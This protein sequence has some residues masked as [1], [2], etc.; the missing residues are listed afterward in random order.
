M[1]MSGTGQVLQTTGGT[2]KIDVFFTHAPFSLSLSIF[3]KHACH[4]P[5]VLI[6]FISK[7]GLFL[8]IISATARHRW[9]QF[10]LH[11]SC[12]VLQVYNAVSLHF[13]V[14]Y[15][16]LLLFPPICVWDLWKALMT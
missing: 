8:V 9:S 5:A 15:L 1:L 2:Q 13:A 16:F 7:D 4:C 6:S 10:P 3:I 11:P 12:H 14:C